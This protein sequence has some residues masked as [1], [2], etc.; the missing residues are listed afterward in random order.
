VSERTQDALWRHDLK[1]Q[2]G[3][4]LGFSELV[5]DEIGAEHPLR[6][7]VQ[8]ILTAARRA[9]ELVSQLDPPT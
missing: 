8:E 6:A 9:M 1:N 7:D 2:L 5:L 4:V 3:I